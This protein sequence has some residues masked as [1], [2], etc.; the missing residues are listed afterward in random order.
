MTTQDDI[1]PQPVTIP[2]P[3]INGKNLS[4]DLSVGD[5]FFML[6][7]NGSG[8][9][10]LLYKILRDLEDE[11]CV[12]MSAYRMNSFYDDQINYDSIEYETVSQKLQQN[13]R[14]KLRRYRINNDF[15]HYDSDILKEPSFSVRQLIHNSIS[16]STKLQQKVKAG[17]CV[18]KTDA[19]TEIDLLNSILK[20]SG[21]VIEL[22]L[23]DQNQ[24]MAQ[25]NAYSPIKKYS[26]QQLSDGERA[27]LIITS[28]I[29]CAKPGS[30]IY[31]DEPER[32]LHRR[33]VSSLLSEL[34]QRRK[35]CIFIISTHEI[36]LPTYVHNSKI[37]LV[38]QCIYENAE[39]TQWDVD[40][41]NQQDEQYT[42]LE[43][44]LKV[45]L[46][47][48]RKIMLFVEGTS[49]SL[50]TPLYQT[51][52]PT[53]SVISKGSCEVVEQSVK[54][55]RH[56]QGTHWVEA[57]GIIDNDNKNP[58]E[59]ENLAKEY[60]FCLNVYSIESIYYHPQ[61]IQ[62]TLEYSKDINNIKNIND[63]YAEITQLMQDELTKQ[64]KH[65][66]GRA[67]NM[68]VRSEIMASMPKQADIEQ[69]NI[70]EKTVNIPALLEKEYQQF[71]QYLANCNYESLMSHYP[72]RE[73]NL[74]NPIAKKCGFADRQRYEHNV[75]L[76]IQKN[77]DA[78]AFILS[79]LGGADQEISK[80][81][82]N[83]KAV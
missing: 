5:V 6:G 83:N 66:C 67:V 45:D 39:P 63:T 16:N 73:A 82:T 53:I 24:L 34:I 51:L 12:L 21:F 54:G 47:V 50:D 38:R 48:S 42:A 49:A 77:N 29:L 20:K 61:I 60:V 81:V 70:Y 80:A 30:F 55:L 8:K 3:T 52:F 2:I 72:I 78:R 79:L 41:I 9:S 11:N 56:N 14:N 58:T 28:N 59:I 22:F 71:D 10:S 69:K 35:D 1:N 64:K 33:L 31:L 23:N 26:I 18:N 17:K 7:A 75:T 37:F 27:A 76:M 4:I 46:L 19:I 36:S 25:N 32:H 65:L 40:I 15:L 68:K 74:L 57:F 43:E 13:Y 44:V 62:W